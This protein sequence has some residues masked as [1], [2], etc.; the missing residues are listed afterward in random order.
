MYSTAHYMGG[1]A[2]APSCTLLDPP[3][4]SLHMH[5]NVHTQC[6]QNMFFGTLVSVCKNHLWK[7]IGVD[8]NHIRVGKCTL[9]W[10]PSN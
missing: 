5:L 10:M 8:P 9:V 1:G 2:E 7:W 6:T 3:M 4:I